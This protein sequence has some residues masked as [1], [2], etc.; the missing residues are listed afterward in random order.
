MTDDTKNKKSVQLYKPLS[1]IRILNNKRD[2]IH[3]NQLLSTYNNNYHKVVEKITVSI[4]VGIG[5]W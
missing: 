4:G 1:K 2:K 5:F 3:T